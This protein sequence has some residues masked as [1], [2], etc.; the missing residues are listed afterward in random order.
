MLSTSPLCS[1]WNSIPVG[2]MASAPSAPDSTADA[3]NRDAIVGIR[4]EPYTVVAPASSH[5]ARNSEKSNVF[6]PFR[7]N[8]LISSRAHAPRHAR[9]SGSAEGEGH[10]DQEPTRSEK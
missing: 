8:V 9:R 10:E 7:P 2:R 4:R 6:E 1:P 3:P 5:G